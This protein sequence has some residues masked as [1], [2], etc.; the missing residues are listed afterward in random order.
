MGNE[1]AK[2]SFWDLQKLEQGPD[3]SDVK[4]KTRGGAK[5]GR[6]RPKGSGRAGARKSSLDMSFN[7]TP[8]FSNESRSN[9]TSSIGD[10]KSIG[11]S[12]VDSRRVGEVQADTFR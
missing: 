2:F 9:E 8:S 1:K 7:G 3:E 6:G 5:R 11:E 4:M 12:L 10:S